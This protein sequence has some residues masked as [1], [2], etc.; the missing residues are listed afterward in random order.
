MGTVTELSKDSETDENMVGSQGH[1]QVTRRE[2]HFAFDPRD[3]TLS[4]ERT[5]QQPHSNAFLSP[6]TL[7][8]ALLTKTS[9]H[10]VTAVVVAEARDHLVPNAIAQAA[11]TTPDVARAKVLDKYSPKE[12]ATATAMVQGSCM[13][14]TEQSP[15]PVLL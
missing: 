7:L 3:R 15:S 8:I 12:I 1:R 5:P 14:V 9:V 2:F 10:H 11:A 4:S 13:Q 6:A